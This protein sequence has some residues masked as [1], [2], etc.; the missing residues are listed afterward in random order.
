MYLKSDTI[1]KAT[2]GEDSGDK[3][4]HVIR[5]YL[6]PQEQSYCFYLRKGVIHCEMTT[7]SGQEVQIML[8]KLVLPVCF[9]SMVL[10]NLS[11]TF[12]LYQPHMANALFGRARWSYSPT[13]NDVTATSYRVHV[14]IFC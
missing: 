14:E 4:L 7:T 3:I 2:F 10:T 8:S 1:N 9:H 5:N 11:N 12:N 6:I 13:I